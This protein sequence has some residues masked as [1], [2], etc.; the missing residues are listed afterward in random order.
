[1]SYRSNTVRLRPGQ[2]LHLKISP[3]F[4]A[5]DKNQIRD[6]EPKHRGCLFQD[7]WEMV[8]SSIVLSTVARTRI[9]LSKNNYW[10][11]ELVY[12]SLG[13]QSLSCALNI[14]LLFLKETLIFCRLIL[15]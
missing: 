9:G 1:M 8:I 12:R 6:I 14:I 11:S 10:F 7:E 13:G 5:A 3:E 2:H 4:H 15:M